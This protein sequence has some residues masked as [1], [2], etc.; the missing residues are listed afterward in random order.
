MRFTL[1]L[2]A[3]LAV[4]SLAA[5]VR[6]DAELRAEVLGKPLVIRTTTRTAGAIDSLRWGGFE[7]IDTLDHGRQL[8]SALNADVEGVFYPEAYNPTEAGSLR[9]HTGPASS[10]RLAFLQVA[11]GELQTRSRMAYWLAPGEKTLG[12]PG[13][14]TS[15]LS[16]HELAKRVRVGWRGVPN[17]L[18]YRVTFRVPDDRPHRLL[19]FEVLTGYMPAAFSVPLEFHAHEGKLLPMRPRTGEGPLPVV[20]STSDGAHAMGVVVAERPP[21]MRGPG[22]GA[23][24][25]RTEQVVKWNCVF[26]LRSEHPIPPAEHAFHVLVVL[27][28]R[29][30]CEQALVQIHA[31]LATPGR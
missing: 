18:D 17:V 6:G 12:K 25:F 24:A 16:G 21:G 2:T 10:S 14:N 4:G 13:L 7:Y 8:Q 15:V 27:G 29:T 22:Y 28:P 23:F 9:D 3:L 1:A 20:L 5:Q 19:Q 11:D 26:R 30:A 31:L